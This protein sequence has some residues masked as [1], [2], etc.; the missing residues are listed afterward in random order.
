M[1]KP[2]IAKYSLSL[3]TVFLL[4]FLFISCGYGVTISTPPP[5]PKPPVTKQA[6][7]TVAAGESSVYFISVNAGDRLTGTFTISGGSGNDV[8]FS[9]KDPTGNTVLTGGRVSR[10]WQ[11]DFVCASTGS[12]Q[13][14]FDNSFSLV[15]NKAVNLNMTVYPKQ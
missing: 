3:L 1:K 6:A 11:F 5:T 8:N 2:T 7:L 4:T 12:Y 10:N 15:S 14:L 9:V 13:L